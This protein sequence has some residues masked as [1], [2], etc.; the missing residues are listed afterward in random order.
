LTRAARHWPGVVLL[1]RRKAPQAALH[2]RKAG[3]AADAN[4]RKLLPALGDRLTHFDAMP[5]H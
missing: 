1:Q 4:G 3:E 2:G 5:L